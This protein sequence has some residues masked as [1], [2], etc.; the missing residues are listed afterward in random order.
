MPLTLDLCQ[1]QHTKLT[2]SGPAATKQIRPLFS[3]RGAEVVLDT[4]DHTVCDGVLVAWAEWAKLS[5]HPS[6]R[7]PAMRFAVVTPRGEQSVAWAL[8]LDSPPR[9]WWW[10]KPGQK[11]LS[12][13]VPWQQLVRVTGLL[14]AFLCLGFCF[15]ERATDGSL[16]SEDWALNME[17]CDIIN[18]TEEG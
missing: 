18:E 12:T 11:C 14:L 1:P 17:I 13:G 9:R 15:P 5:T 16:R 3:S 2:V 4:R 8:Q 7:R 6:Q 10:R